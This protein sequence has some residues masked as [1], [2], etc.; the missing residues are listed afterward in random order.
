MM[1]KVLL[2]RVRLSEVEVLGFRVRVLGLRRVVK[3]TS[4]NSSEY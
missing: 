4:F 3:C 1:V 2:R